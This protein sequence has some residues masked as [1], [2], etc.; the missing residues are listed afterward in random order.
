[1]NMAHF[2]VR[3]GRAEGGVSF[4]STFTLTRWLS[5]KTWRVFANISN[6]RVQPKEKNQN[7][8]KTCS[9]TLVHLKCL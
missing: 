5:H 9:Q 3:E 6:A 8:P 4:T 7:L 1:M 2:G